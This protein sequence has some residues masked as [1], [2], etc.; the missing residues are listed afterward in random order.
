MVERLSWRRRKGL[1]LITQNG[2]TTSSFYVT[3]IYSIWLY[4][5]LLWF[6]G[7]IPQT[8]H[9]LYFLAVEYTHN[10]LHHTSHIQYYICRIKT[11]YVHCK[12]LIIPQTMHWIH[13]AIFNSTLEM[14]ATHSDILMEDSATTIPISQSRKCIVEWLKLYFVSRC[15][16]HHL[17]AGNL[18][19]LISEIVF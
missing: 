16:P 9:Y 5:S 15:I 10:I 12:R 11:V 14:M 4:L 6:L 3:W 7:I 13:K 2:D 18:C 8:L 17:E 1:M 19:V